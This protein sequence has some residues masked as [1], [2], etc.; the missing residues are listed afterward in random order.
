MNKMQE[1]SKIYN[2]HVKT[3]THPQTKPYGWQTSSSEFKR[4]VTKTRGFSMQNTILP[5]KLKRITSSPQTMANQIKRQTWQKMP[6]PPEVENPRFYQ[7]SLDKPQG[8]HKPL[9][10]QSKSMHKWPRHKSHKSENNHQQS[11]AKPTHHPQHEKYGSQ[12]QLIS[13][14]G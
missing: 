13:K 3:P 1:K 6:T 5:L 12:G 11:Q 7:M 4:V 14:Q 10:Q 2:I 8:K 9:N